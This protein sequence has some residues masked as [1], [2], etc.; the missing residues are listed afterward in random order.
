[1]YGPC[2]HVQETNK[3]R[4]AKDFTDN[5]EEQLHKATVMRDLGTPLRAVGALVKEFLFSHAHEP[6]L[7]SDSMRRP[8]G[9]CFEARR[10]SG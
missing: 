9:C 4:H 10:P 1:M 3:G 7:G 6:A 5:I 8:R 2:A